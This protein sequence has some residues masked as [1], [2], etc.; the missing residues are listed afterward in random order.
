ML[1][2][3]PS[4]HPQQ[5]ASILAEGLRRTVKQLPFLSGHIYENETD[6]QRYSWISWSDE[7]ADV[8]FEE[9][10]EEGL[11]SYAE[12]AAAGMPLHNI[13]HRFLPSTA[14]KPDGGRPRRSGMPALVASYVALK[15]GLVVCLGTHHHLCD[16]TGRAMLYN[17]W[18]RNTAGTSPP[19]LLDAHEPLTR[20]QR[21]F[22]TLNLEEGLTNDNPFPDPG[23]E[24]SKILEQ[25]TA[26]PQS[27]GVP[28]NIPEPPAV[29]TKLLTFDLKHLE[30]LREA[31]VNAQ[32]LSVRP[33]IVVVLS[34]L[35]WCLVSQARF[36]CVTRPLVSDAD[37]MAQKDSSENISSMLLLAANVRGV[38]P[39]DSPLHASGTFL[40]NMAAGA[41]SFLS[42]S[43]LAS[44][45]DLVLTGRPHSH[46]LSYPSVLPEV[47]QA[48]QAALASALTVSAATSRLRRAIP[49]PDA[50]VLRLP[51]QQ[52]FGTNKLIVSSWAN[53]SLYPDFGP[54]VGRPE[55]ARVPL[56]RDARLDGTLTVLPRKRWLKEV[57]SETFGEVLETVFRLRSDDM[58]CV[59]E[60]K[61]L[62]GFLSRAPV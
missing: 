7:D 1:S 50:R 60:N 5:T 9:I 43:K 46:P 18:A 57:S 20:F 3:F 6:E 24:V 33:S 61:S 59:L 51:A 13:E 44:G 58:D 23:T 19:V 30:A 55:F 42:M 48:I 45:N 27:S 32:G 52:G 15:G 41:I 36:K 2:C 17:A 4:N 31:L 14:N 62:K 26:Q 34:S 47:V 40:G 53:F 38:Y 37:R 35:L 11:P 16:G 28:E 39:P 56:S 12:L 29:A 22:D 54:D 25:T 10:E 49:A 21:V 8:V